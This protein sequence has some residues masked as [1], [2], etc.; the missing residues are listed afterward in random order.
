MTVN[1]QI[2]GAL[3]VRADFRHVHAR[4]FAESIANP[5]EVYFATDDVT[6]SL[7]LRIRGALAADDEQAVEDALGRFASRWASAGAIFSRIRYGE[8]S[9]F[10]LG[11]PDHV[12]LLARLRDLPGRQLPRT[13][14]PR[15]SA[16]SA[17]HQSDR[18]RLND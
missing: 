11:P 3:P 18:S 12:R 7:V 15:S 2:Q 10:A 1:Y 16:R 5:A 17:R 8:P 14:A 4:K 13:G 9:F 6:H